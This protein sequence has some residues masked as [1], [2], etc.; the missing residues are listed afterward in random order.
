MA[1]SEKIG[2][3]ES[4]LGKEEMG[5]KGHF[6]DKAQNLPIKIKGG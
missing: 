2:L 4:I 6:G 5:K 3:S 1:L